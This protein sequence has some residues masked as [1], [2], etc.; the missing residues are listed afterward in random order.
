MLEWFQKRLAARPDAFTFE[1][2]IIVMIDEAGIS[3]TYPD[4]KIE[5]LLWPQMD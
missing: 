2:K 5:E 3:V 4:G 1:K